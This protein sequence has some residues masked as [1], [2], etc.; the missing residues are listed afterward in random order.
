MKAWIR[1]WSAARQPPS[2]A[3]GGRDFVRQRVADDVAAGR[4][5]GRVVTRFPPEPNG[6]L[7]IGHAKPLCHNF[8]AAMENGGRCHLRMDDTNPAKEDATFVQSIIADIRWLIAGWAE[9]QPAH[10]PAGADPALTTAATGRADY[11]AAVEL[12]V[13]GDAIGLVRPAGP[14]AASRCRR[15]TGSRRG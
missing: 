11:L 8:G 9:A 15:R 2:P 5:G 14:R 10:K 4:N 6:Y 13:T 12:V 3:D 7:H 1:G